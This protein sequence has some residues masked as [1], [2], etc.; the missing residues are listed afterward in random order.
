[1]PKNPLFDDPEEPADGEEPSELPEEP[2]ESDDPEEP[3]EPAGFSASVTT[4]TR[5]AVA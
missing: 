5:L 2:V 4:T 1:M 3:E